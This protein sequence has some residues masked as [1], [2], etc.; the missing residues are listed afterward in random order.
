MHL[1]LTGFPPH[2][3]LPGV[4]SISRREVVVSLLKAEPGQHCVYHKSLF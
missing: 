1:G 4:P 2:K 3:L